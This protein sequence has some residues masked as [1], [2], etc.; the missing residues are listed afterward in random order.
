MPKGAKNVQSEL[1]AMKFA[2]VGLYSV[3]SDDAMIAVHYP[4]A[5][6]VQR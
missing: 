3:Q 6:G 4:D 5:K 2:S 1:R